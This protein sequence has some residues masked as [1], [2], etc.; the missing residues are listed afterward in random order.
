MQF[1]T[2]NNA[3]II[4]FKTYSCSTLGKKL[5]MYT[6]YADSN[7]QPWRQTEEHFTS[8]I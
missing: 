5:N 3:K 6:H 8:F 7:T 2:T 1:V 4:L